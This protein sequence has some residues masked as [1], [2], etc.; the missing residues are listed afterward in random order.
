MN[1]RSGFTLIELLVV[2]AIIA[3]LIGLLLPAVQKVREAAAR[4][5]CSNNL[6][7]MS[8][9]L[10]SHHDSRGYFPQ[11]RS[12]P[13]AVGQPA[14]TYSVHTHL[15]PF[16]EQDNVYKLV[17]FTVDWGHANNLVP[18][19]AVVKSYFCPSEPNLGA[20][21]NGWAPSS[22][23]VNEGSN[24]KFVPHTS[25]PTLP[26]GNGPFWINKQFRFGDISD[27]TSNTAAFTERM[28]G[29]FTNA[30]ANELRDGYVLTQTPQT[31]DE[32]MTICQS[33]DW[34][35]LSYQGYSNNGGPWL[36]GAAQSTVIHFSVPPFARQCLYPNNFTM[37]S[38]ASSFHTGGVMVGMCD[39]SVRF[40]AKSVSLATWR[41]VGSRNGGEVIGGDW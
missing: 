20:I 35:N 36:A 40:A 15:L 25:N 18:R 39:G 16:M 21:P 32:A 28:F 1:R 38:A 41:A 24:I 2:I 9:A 27:G 4:I 10:H 11:S 34:Q 31:P 37:V 6:K 13:L 8:L 5:Q 22:Y 30:S 3:I 12:V 29:D 7:Q 14:I 19:G 17:D 23:R 26:D 33:L